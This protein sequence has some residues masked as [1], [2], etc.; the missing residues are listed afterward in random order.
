MLPSCPHCGNND[1]R[2]IEKFIE[3]QSQIKEEAVA[4]RSHGTKYYCEVCGKSWIVQR[5]PLE[6]PDGSAR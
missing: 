5:L 3:P 2:M 1:E 6:G 4:Q